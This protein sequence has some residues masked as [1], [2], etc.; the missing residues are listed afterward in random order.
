METVLCNAFKWCNIKT[1][2][3]EKTDEI[4]ESK[5]YKKMKDSFFVFDCTDLLYYKCHKISLNGSK[6]YVDS[7]G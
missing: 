4:I 7:T 6:S 5:A 2:T 3:G 1:M